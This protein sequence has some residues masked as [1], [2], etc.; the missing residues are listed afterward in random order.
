MQAGGGRLPGREG[1]DPVVVLGQDLAEAASPV[2]PGAVADL[3]RVTGSRVMVTGKRLG[4]GAVVAENLRLLQTPDITSR[5]AAPAWRGASWAASGVCQ[6]AVMR[7]GLGHRLWRW[8]AASVVVA[9]GLAVL[10][11]AFVRAGLM[12]AGA[13]AAVLVVVPLGVS[14]LVWARRSYGTDV[15]VTVDQ[16]RKARHDLAEMIREKW[17][18]EFGARRLYDPNPIVVKWRLA[19]RPVADVS[20]DVTTGTRGLVGRADQ[21]SELASWLR[22]LG[23]HRLVITGDPGMGKTTLAVQMLLELLKQEPADERVPVPVNGH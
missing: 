2:R 21:V 4:A 18:A 8:A 11:V 6:D 1:M 14:L 12:G 20:A 9:A 13:A 10:G 15:R 3:A 19:G 23:R 22:D 5:Y 17:L 16:A 7:H